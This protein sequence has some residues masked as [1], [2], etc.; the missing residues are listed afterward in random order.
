MQTQTG[1]QF[2]TWND[3]RCAYEFKEGQGVPL[4][5]I[6]PIGVGL[7]RQFWHR[8]IDA[9]QPNPIYNPDLLGCGESEMPHV[10]YSPIDWARQLQF[11]LKTVIQTPAIVVTQG[12]LSPVAIELATIEPD[13]VHSIVLSG[14]PALPLV[15]RN[16][17]ERSHRLVWNLADSPFGVGFYRYARRSQFLKRFSVQQLFADPAQVDAEWLTTLQR[18]AENLASRHAVFSFLA[19]FWRQD[20]TKKMA[21]IQQPVFVVFGDRATSISREGKGETVSDRL[22]DY[23]KAFPNATGTTIKGRNVLPYESTADFVAAI[24]PFTRTP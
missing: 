18:G 14:P 23:L 5:L 8:F 6:H 20:Y 11:F 24:A 12:A 22:T 7:S 4:L 13:L 3:Y 1:T 17:A 2:Y 21:Q 19:G 10:A 15:S 9:W 16:T